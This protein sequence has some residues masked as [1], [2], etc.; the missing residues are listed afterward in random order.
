MSLDEPQDHQH[1]ER[2]IGQNVM[3]APSRQ[4]TIAGSVTI[5]LTQTSR[6]SAAAP[7]P[8]EAQIKFMGTVTRS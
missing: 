6:G 4:R 7:G 2:D 1:G 3:N 5:P 8:A